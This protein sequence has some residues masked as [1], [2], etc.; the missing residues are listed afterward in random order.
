MRPSGFRARAGTEAVGQSRSWDRS[1]G[2]RTE[3]DFAGTNP[4]PVGRTRFPQ[5]EAGARGIE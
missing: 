3:Q 2:R 5:D 4:G 1:R